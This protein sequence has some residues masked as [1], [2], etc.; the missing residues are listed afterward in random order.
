MLVVVERLPEANPDIEQA[1]TGA[2]AAEKSARDQ[3]PQAGI[4]K[5]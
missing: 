5:Q 1:Q 3:S 2:D 4:G